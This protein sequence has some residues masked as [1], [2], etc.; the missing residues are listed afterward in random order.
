MSD[1]R[2]LRSLLE[3]SKAMAAEIDLDALLEVILSH[4]TEV[5]AA[6]RSSLF[7]YEEATHTLTN[8]IS[9][10][11]QRGSVRVS[12]GVGIAGHVAKAQRLLNVPDAYADPRFNP[13]FDKETGFRTRSILCA[14]MVARN[15]RLM[16]VLQVLNKAGGGAFSAEDEELLLAFASHAAIAVDRAQLVEAFV[17]KERIEESLRL[18]HDIQLGMLPRSF[19]ER[20][21]VRSFARLLPARSVGGDLYDV[22]DLGD[23]IFFVVGDVSGKGVPAALFM[24]VTKTLFRASAETER[25]PAAV[26]ARV[27]RELSRD[28]ERSMFVTAF[29]GCLD[30]EGRELQF[31]NAGHNP[32]YRVAAGGA[33]SEVLGAHGM[34]MGILEEFPYTT[35]TLKLAAGDGVF[36]FT[37]GV[38]EALNHRQQQFGAERLTSFL[39]ANARGA[40][41]QVVNGILAE[42]TAFVGTTPQFDDIAV[43]S[44]QLSDSKRT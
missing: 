38:V 31:S 5:M 16:G 3:V 15:G 22:V 21:G 42:L 20:P 10:S 26:L 18:A 35:E 30:V 34:A 32:P 28:N 36:L 12:L 24:A 14:P 27:N 9:G 19:P 11:L 7:I 25:S 23:R 41:E 2:R 13:A 40:P 8:Q 1:V 6:E 4:A 44:L 29:V 43:L 37:D 17:E 39:H 33:I